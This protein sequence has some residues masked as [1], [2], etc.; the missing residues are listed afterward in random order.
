MRLFIFMGLLLASFGA[1][2]DSAGRKPLA[3]VAI[4]AQQKQIHDDVI[5]VRGRYKD[6][7]SSKRVDLLAK[8]A[9]LMAMLEGKTTTDELSE[10]EQ[11]EAFNTLEWIEAAINNAEDER[12]VCRREKVL[13]STRLTRVCRTVEEERRMKE[14]ARDQ[15]DR[16]DAQMRR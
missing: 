7:P 12:M 13:G 6:M 8:Q 4:T 10:S 2:A 1:F 16:G 5:A 3:V 15:L 14:L 9:G 11:T